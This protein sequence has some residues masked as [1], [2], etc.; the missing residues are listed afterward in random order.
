V[1]RDKVEDFIANRANPPELHEL[2]SEC[3]DD[4]SVE[5]PPMS[6]NLIDGAGI[7]LVRPRLHKAAAHEPIHHGCAPQ[8][9]GLAFRSK[10]SIGVASGAAQMRE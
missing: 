7:E 9:E 4:G 5:S 1:L 10:G 8:Q 2:L 6:S 3:L